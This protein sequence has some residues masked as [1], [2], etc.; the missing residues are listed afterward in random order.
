MQRWAQPTILTM[1]VYTKLTTEEFAEFLKTFDVGELTDFQGISQGIENTNYFVNTSNAGQSHH[2]VLTIFE[3]L[4]IEELPYFLE[5]T[6]FLA[7]QGLPIAHPQASRQQQYLQSLKDKPAALVQRLDGQSIKH[8]ELEHCQQVGHVLAQMHS[9]GERFS[10]RRQNPRG[11][12]WYCEAA[13]KVKPHLDVTEAQLLE[14]ELALQAQH[15]SLNLPAGVI[16]ADLF[17]DNVL[18][19]NDKLSGVID[20]YYACDGLFLYDLAITVNDWCSNTDGGLNPES[21]NALINAYNKVR[22]LSQE[23]QSAWPIMLRAAALRFWLSRLVDWHFP[24]PGV[25]T[26]AHDPAVFFNIL[27]HHASAHDRLLTSWC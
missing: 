17:H 14:Q 13:E 12:S 11:F 8:P 26:H 9:A 24:R 22:P 1:S 20:F 19:S 16:H 10:L 6:A 23:E 3:S 18:F 21:T 25:L 4:S 27:Q 2:F 7:E 5:L 15:Q